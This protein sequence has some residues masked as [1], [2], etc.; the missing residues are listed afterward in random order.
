MPPM[1]GTGDISYRTA[2][3]VCAELLKR[4][5]PLLAVSRLGQNKP[6]PKNSGDTIRFRGYEP[7]DNNPK[8]LIEGVTPA[9]S[10]PTYREVVAKIEQY[11]DWIELTD[12][13]SDTHEDPLWAEF[14]D[15]LGEEAGIMLERVVINKLL[16][17]TNAFFAGETGGVQAST[18]NGVNLPLTLTMQRRVTRALKRQ[19][20]T[21]ITRVVTASANFNTSPISPSYIAVC[22]T[23]LEADIRN[24]PG[25]VPTEKYASYHPMDGEIGSVEGVRYVGTTLL[26]P[27][28]DAGAAPAVGTEVE[29]QAGA[30]ADVYPVLYFGKNAFG[31]TPFAAQKG[32][33]N[34]PV[35]VM[36]LNPNTPR[37]SDP[38]GQRGSLAW[39]A[40]RTSEILY[41]LWMAR[42]EVAVTKL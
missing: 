5:Q 38:M 20:A 16:A 35:N 42:V 18:R 13:L 1:T 19:L 7:L 8:V 10:K 37:S 40:Y 25:F 27:K 15:L 22:H 4:A 26:E 39:K 41:D 31:V 14:S 33:G 3:Y 30:C 21:P 34:S 12:K 11:G 6:I 32:K 17:G 9:A 29:S 24:M 23:D 2:G 36:V 28:V